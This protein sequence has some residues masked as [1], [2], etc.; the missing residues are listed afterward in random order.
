V[1]TAAFLTAFERRFPAR[2]RGVPATRYTLGLIRRLIDP[3]PTVRGMTAPRNQRLLN[4]AVAH[5]PEGEAYL[6]VGVFQGKT[7]ISALRGNPR[8]PAYACDNFSEFEGSSSLAVLRH[9]LAHHGLDDS[10]TFLNTDFRTALLAGSIAHQAGVYFYDGAHDEQSQYEGILLA[11]RV[12]ADE[13]LVIVDD[14]RYAPDSGS[15]AEAGTLRAMADSNNNWTVLLTLPAR[16]NGDNAMWW[17]G[18]GILRFRRRARP[19]P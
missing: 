4:L 11:E 3:C 2:T 17:N 19:A 9:N 16:H 18:V 6:E 5:L 1:N 10:V 14:W 12:L 8:R 15:R 13:A 7:L